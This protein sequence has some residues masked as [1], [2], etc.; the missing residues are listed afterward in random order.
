MQKYVPEKSDYI[1]MMPKDQEYVS[2][3]GVILRQG[4]V[5]FSAH[6]NLMVS[7]GRLITSA[8]QH[9]QGDIRYKHDKQRNNQSLKGAVVVIHCQ[10]E[11]EVKSQF[12]RQCPF[13]I[14]HLP[15]S[16]GG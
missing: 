12:G 6:I 10:N 9:G 8:K 16:C 7:A 11:A 15:H 4:G 1:N 13:E 3:E 5:R 2:S 14:L